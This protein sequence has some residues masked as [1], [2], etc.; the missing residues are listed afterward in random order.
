MHNVHYVFMPGR[1][2]DEL[3]WHTVYCMMTV[4]MYIYVFMSDFVVRRGSQTYWKN[5]PALIFY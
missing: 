4:C 3:R 2:D 5:M 1:A